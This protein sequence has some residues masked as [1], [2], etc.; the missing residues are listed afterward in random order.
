[1]ADPTYISDASSVAARMTALFERDPKL[2]RVVV[3]RGASARVYV[4]PFR[5][6]RLEPGLVGVYT[7]DVRIVDILADVNP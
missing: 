3:W 5:E 1:M 2:E 4:Q 7:R 6:Q